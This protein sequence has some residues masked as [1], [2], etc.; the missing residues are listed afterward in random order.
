MAFGNRTIGMAQNVGT[1]LKALERELAFNRSVNAKSSG[2]LYMAKQS[3]LATPP[4]SAI[5]AVIAWKSGVS[6]GLS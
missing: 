4:L 1:Y 5:A 2:W 3:G 6:V